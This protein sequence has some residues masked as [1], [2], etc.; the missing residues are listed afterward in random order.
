MTNAIIVGDG[1]GGLSCALFLAKNGIE[2]TIF[3]QD[4][5]A[6][7][8]ALLYNYL[9]I[10]KILGSDFQKIARQQV[11]DFGAKLADA[12]VTE[13]A[14]SDD[15]FRVTTEDG[16]THTAKYVVLAE[17]KGVKLNQSLGLT[18]EGRSVEVDRNGRTAVPGLYAVGR[19]TK[20][21]RSQAIIS[22]GEGASTALD[23]LSTEAGRDVLDYDSPPKE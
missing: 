16:T 2:T 17:G 20:M 6:M 21:N 10:P 7:H 3:G 11:L 14:K 12:L 1:P 18:K 22:A 4:N 15:G 9:G 19:S 8:Y 23:I 13:V 5:T